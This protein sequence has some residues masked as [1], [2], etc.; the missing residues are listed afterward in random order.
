MNIAVARPRPIV[1][2]FCAAILPAGAMFCAPTGIPSAAAQPCPDVDVV[3][4]RGLGDAPGPGPLGDA[5]IN[6]LR[7]KVGGRSVG[8]HGVNY[9]AS[10]NFLRVSD[11][12]AD[13]TNHV[14]YMI[15]NCPATRLVLG[16]FSEGAVVVDFLVG[17][18][19][20]VPAIPGVPGLPAGLPPLPPIPGL[21]IPLP[22]LDILSGVGPTN[23]LPPAA[24]DHVAAVAVFGDPLNKVAGPLNA[25]SPGVRAQDDR[26]V[27]RGRPDLR[28]GRRHE[29]A[30]RVRARADGPGR[31]ICRGPA[32]MR[33]EKDESRAQ[34]PVRS[35]RESKSLL[36]GQS[37]VTV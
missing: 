20:S 25:R 22:G 32:L 17:A 37:P 34:S 18:A 23:P 12:V 10:S 21:P 7:S 11:G 2:R 24:N 5:F 9:P 26:L 33:A 6:S 4:A 27:P 29:R 19:P 31:D 14:N 36:N 16:G 3:F 35:T 28:W 13:A 30:S 1:S 8:V 15:A